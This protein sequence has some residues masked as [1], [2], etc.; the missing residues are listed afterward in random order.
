[1][2]TPVALTLTAL[3]ILH[4]V[5][6]T[7]TGA[8]QEER[9]SVSPL[10][11]I[12]TL[13]AAIQK[14]FEK[15]DRRFGYTRLLLPNGAHGFA[16]ENDEEISSLRE[17]EDANLRVALYLASRRFVT[18]TPDQPV[19]HTTDR[20]KGPLSITRGLSGATPSAASMR[21]EGRKAFQLF[22]R[23]DPQHEF[24]IGQWMVVARPV[25][26]INATCL[27][28]HKSSDD[29]WPTNNSDLRVGDVL[30][31]VFYAY[32]PAVAVR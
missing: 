20:I 19:G 12:L 11:A 27:T 29:H 16:P 10:G 24:Q 17:L 8:A 22:E 4:A 21:S 3:T 26:A 25:R 7:R 32:Q 6:A 30:G 28:C 31:V 23:K 15:V 5:A 14:R 9:A 13:D 2:R 18:A 1:M